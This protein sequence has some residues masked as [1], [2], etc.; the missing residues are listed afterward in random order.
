MSFEWHL[1][2]ENRIETYHD[3]LEGA[4]MSA[5]ALHVE[6]KYVWQGMS[7]ILKYLRCIF[8]CDA[9][10]Q[11]GFTACLR[12][13]VYGLADEVRSAFAGILRVFDSPLSSAGGSP[14]DSMP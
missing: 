4:L 14:R 6:T 12:Y 10:E 7:I 13:S 1:E 2:V 5:K 11:V 9:Q 8:D 3:C